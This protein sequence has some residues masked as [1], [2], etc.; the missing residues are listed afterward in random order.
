ME[1]SFAKQENVFMGANRN[2]KEIQAKRWT[3]EIGMG[4]KTPRAAVAGTYVD[5]KCPFTSK[6]SIRGR[7]L[8]GTVVSTKMQRTIIVRRDYMHFVPKYKRYERRHKNVAVH[9]SPAFQVHV[10]DSV[11]IG[12]CR[13]L[14]K[15]VR[16]NVIAHE[17]STAVQMKGFA[18]F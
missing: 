3:K 5:K 14:S 1:R 10:G 15:T 18:K 9:I 7:I 16:F 6:V 13:P 8:R 2:A 4:F 12:E 11:T 17:A